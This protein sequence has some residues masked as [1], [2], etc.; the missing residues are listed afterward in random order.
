[1]RASEATNLY[2]KRAAKQ[3]GIGNRLETVLMAPRREVKVE[4]VIELDN[5][6]LGC[7]NGFRVQHD[8]SRGPMKGGLRYHPEV[9][10]D[11]VNSLASLMTWKTA[12]ANIPYGGAKGGIN[13]DPSK[14]SHA[15]LQRVTRAFIDQIHDII[16]PGQDI[17]AP[18]MGTNAQT[19]AWIVDQYSKY[20]GWNPAVVTGKPLE[21]GGS[22]GREQATGQGLFFAAHAVLADHGVDITKARFAIQGFGNVGS[23]AAR[24]IHQAGGKVVAIAD[25]SG[26]IYHKDGIDID[27]L[28]V[29]VR[30]TGSVKG[31]GDAQE[32]P[33]Q[34]LLTCEC[35][36]LVPAALGNVITEENM[37]D[38]R[39]RFIIEGAN[40]PTTPQADEYLMSKGVIIVPDIFANSGG[41]IVSY[42][43]WVQNIQQFRW[44]I[45]RVNQELKSHILDSYREITSIAKD[46]ECDM[47][48]A[49]FQLAISRVARASAL[50]GLENESFCMINERH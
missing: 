39:A 43:E 34:S 24:F 7:F 3:L 29:H 9:D 5:G 23:W 19:M 36:V 22:E 11:E 31:Y 50:R 44:R 21:L 10:P 25:V 45:D 37:Q 6:E 49:A 26:A 16:G 18:D 30:D 2:F 41:V 14:L 20:H 4:C 27:Q 12:V 48:T 8:N 33:A 35:D 28:L 46:N 40:A 32:I 17:P 15:E 47:R 38:I 42:F 13:C 1:M